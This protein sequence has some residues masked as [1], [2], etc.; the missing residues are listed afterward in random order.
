MFRF[1]FINKGYFKVS[2]TGRDGRR[3]KPDPYIRVIYQY[4]GTYGKM[5]VEK[6][7]IG[8][9]RKERSGTKSYSPK[10]NFGTINF[11]SI[12]CKC[13]V[14]FYK[15]LKDLY[16]RSGRKSPYDTLHVRSS[17]LIHGGTPYATTDVIRIPRKTKSISY[18]TA[19]HELA[20]RVRHSYD[21]NI[22]H[23]GKDVIKYKYTQHHHC[24]KKTNQGFAF[25]EGWAEFWAGTCTGGA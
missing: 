25:N 4:S 20:H 13:Y 21:G 17:V 16:D 22:L 9:N 18:E 10:I 24:G 11:N 1:V 2:G 14:Q 15:A 7:L 5:E 3:G 6:N 23:F 8:P 19:K 12:H